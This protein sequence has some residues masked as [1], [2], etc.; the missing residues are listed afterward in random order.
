MQRRD[1]LWSCAGA[2]ASAA[3][4]KVAAPRDGRSETRRVLYVMAQLTQ[5]DA[6]ALH[7]LT[8]TLG[9]SGFNVFI[10]SFLQAE[11]SDSKVMLSY[12]GNPLSAFVPGVPASLAHLR[13][14]FAERKRLLLSIGGWNHA[15]TFEAIRSAGVPA[16]VRQ[17]S[18]QIIT[19]LGL[20]GID[21]DLEPGVGGI[22]QW[23]GVHREYG[24]TIVELTNEYKRLYPSHV[25][26]HAPVAPVAAELYTKPTA[27]PGLPQ[28]L[29]AG[30][31]AG[32]KN[33]IGWLNVQLY[34]GGEIAG[35]D[36]AGFY[37]DSLVKPLLAMRAQ[38]GI[39]MPLPFLI[40][41]FEPAA[42]QPLEFC[43][44]T[45]AAIDKGCEELHAGKVSGIALWDYRQVQP[46]IAEWSRGIET[47]LQS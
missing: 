28:G 15:Q 5:T 45:I 19:P 40:P 26:T 30:T 36:I 3:V 18:E 42:K 6:T 31:R 22:E 12:N 38:T 7:E 1:F 41:L 29:L 14:G 35:G 24:K 32:D 25:V 37:R 39:A 16:F 11:Y 43:Q 20:D 13:A 47:V 10:L 34:E 4:A 23:F 8:E 27:L 2:L 44:Q 33:N 46:A 21:L 17:L 9:S